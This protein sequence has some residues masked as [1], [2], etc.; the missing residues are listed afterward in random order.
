MNDLPTM[1]RREQSTDDISVTLN[2]RVR[3]PYQV[4]TAGVSGYLDIP[5]QALAAALRLL[6]WKCE[7]P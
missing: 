3:I 7:P 5:A 1:T 6:G 2:G 4:P